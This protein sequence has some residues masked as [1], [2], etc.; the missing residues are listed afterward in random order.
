MTHSLTL[1]EDIRI[2]IH[3]MLINP[4]AAP[5]EAQTCPRWLNKELKFLLSALHTTLM[6][7]MLDLLH[8]NLRRDNKEKK[9]L[10]ATAF[11]S[12][13]TLAMVT[14]SM[15]VSVRCKQATDEEMGITPPEDPQ[16]EINGMDDRLDWLSEIFRQKYGNT[17]NKNGKGR[18]EFNPLEDLNDRRSLDQPAQTFACDVDRI[19]EH[20][21]KSLIPYQKQS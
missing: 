13:L 4:P 8:K 21:R 7:K 2:A 14:E 12:I 19:V 18:K 20:Y 9:S 17:G 10:W 6:K 5:Y 11:M 16:K 15:Q 1:T 3:A